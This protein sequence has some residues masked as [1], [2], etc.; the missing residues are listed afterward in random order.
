MIRI[1]VDSSADYTA[2]ELEALN[3]ELV[4]INITLNDKN[5]HDGIDIISMLCLESLD[6]PHELDPLAAVLAI[7]IRSDTKPL[8]KVSPILCS[9]L[10]VAGVSNG[11]TQ[12]CHLLSGPRMLK[13]ILSKA[14]QSSKTQKSRTQNN[15]NLHVS[16]LFKM[17]PSGSFTFRMVIL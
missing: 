9:A 12:I 13:G 1:L 17:E 7:T 16:L 11:V 14:R 15:S 5:Y 6:L 4:P 3:M 10:S 2:Q 8:L